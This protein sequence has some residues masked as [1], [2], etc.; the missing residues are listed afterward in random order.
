MERGRPVLLAAALL[1]VPACHDEDDE[2]AGGTLET[3]AEGLEVPWAV[4]ELPDGSLLVT[5]R[6]RGRVVRVVG[7]RVDVV[8]TLPVR[9]G[10]E[11]GLLGIAAHPDVA[12]HGWIYVYSTRAGP[13]NRVS[14][15]TFDGASLRDEVVILDGIPAADIHNGGRLAFGPD[16]RLYVAT[17]DAAVPGLAQDLRS[18]AGKILRMND[19]GSVPDDNPF[20]TL[21]YSYGHRNP[22]GLAWTD[23][24]TLYATEHGPSAHDE[25]NRIRAGGN[26]GWPAAVCSD[27][28]GFVAPLRCFDEFTLAPAGA[29]FDAGGRLYVAGLR[30]EQVRR[31]TIV[32]DDVVEEEIVLSGV[33]RLR[34]VL[35]RDGVLLAGTSNRDGRGAPAP[36]DDRLLRLRVAP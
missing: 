13:L 34:A 10:G 12:A 22:Q 7:D 9:A 36:N 33:G 15:F 20:G 14:R 25:I 18:L 11:G 5:E 29:A 1:V 24:G 6:D 32:G 27:H 31:L 3:V 23:D 30:G 28:A 16:G 17:G 21:V 19:D 8:A 2:D 35:L 26:Y 4:A